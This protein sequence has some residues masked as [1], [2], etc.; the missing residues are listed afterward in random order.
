MIILHLGRRPRQQ[1]YTMQPQHLVL[2]PCFSLHGQK[3]GFK[4]TTWYLIFIIYVFGFLAFAN[5]LAPLASS[6]HDL[7]H[8][9]GYFAAKCEEAEMGVSSVKSEVMARKQ[10][11]SPSWF[12]V[13][14]CPK[15][16][17]LSISGLVHKRWENGVRDGQAVWCGIGSTVVGLLDWMVKRELSWNVK[18]WFN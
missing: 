5:N 4:L 12:R 3:F 2:N 7:Q 15:Q 14:W 10:Q 18:P 11:I 1:Q 6:V 8:V 17:S 9:L 13:S 16:R